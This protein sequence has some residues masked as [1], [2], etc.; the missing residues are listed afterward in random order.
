MPKRVVL[1][2]KRG[3]LRTPENDNSKRMCRRC[4]VVYDLA[5]Q[6]AHRQAHIANQAAYALTARGM[7][8]AVR[9]ESK[10]RGN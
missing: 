5:Y 2:C 7:L 10:R 6:T 9:Y 3:H 1:T 4:K 8:A